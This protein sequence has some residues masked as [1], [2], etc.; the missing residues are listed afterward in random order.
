MEPQQVVFEVSPDSFQADVVERSN[1]A[2]VVLLFWADQVPQSVQMK[3]AL[4]SLVGGYAGKALLGLVDVSRDQSLAQH[5]RVQGLPSVRVIKDGQIVEQV[6]G[7]QEPAALQSMLDQLTMSSGDLVRGQ[8]ETLLAAGDF[9]SALGLLQ[10]AINEE[11]N[12][13][14]LRVELANVLISKGDLDGARVALGGVPEDTEGR[15]KPQARLEF[16]EEAAGMG[17]RDDIEQELAANGD[18][19]E[20]RYRL[21]I[22]EAAAGNF[23]QGLEAA[24]HILQTDREF[25]DDIGRVTMIRMF[26]ALGKDSELATAYRRRMFN[27]MH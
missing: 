13:P 4:E 22:V 11:P 3:Q 18:D 25:R 16:A 17:S 23:E 6:D 5:L 14:A 27:Y 2:A 24:M 8:I 19:L 15:N 26:D 9:D 20:A 10:Q 1:E 12:N 7:P 21:A